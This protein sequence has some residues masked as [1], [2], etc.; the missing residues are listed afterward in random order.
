MTLPLLSLKWNESLYVDNGKV[1]RFIDLD[2]YDN[3][4]EPCSEPQ[5]SYV[6]SIHV[7]HPSFCLS[8]LSST[9]GIAQPNS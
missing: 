9:S 5:R 3:F 7:L 2:A 4:I 6:G 1:T 8:I